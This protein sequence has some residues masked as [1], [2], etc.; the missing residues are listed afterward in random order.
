MTA[1]YLGE[2]DYGGSISVIHNDS[3]NASSGHQGPIVVDDAQL[4]F[5]AHFHR[6]GPDLI[7]TGR[8]GH[9]HIV[10]DYFATEHPRALAAPNGAVLRSDLV[11]LL[12]GSVA[13]NEYAQAGGAAPSAPQPIGRVEKIVGEVTVLRNGVAVTLNV[14]DAVYQSDVVQ[15]GANSSAGIAFPDG[16]AFNLVANTRMALSDYSYDANSNSNSALFNLV[17]GGFSFVAGKVA[18]TGDMKIGTPAATMGIRGTAGWVF[19]DQVA[20][21]TANAGNVTVHFSAVFDSVTNTESTYTLYAVDANGQL[22]HDPNGNLISLATVSSTQNGLVTN[23]SINPN[24]IGQ[25]A[26]AVVNVA[27]PDFNQQQFANLVVPQVLDM[28]K[29]AIQ[30]YQNQQNNQN[31]PTNPQSNP[32]SSG[33]GNPQPPSNNNN[34]N[35][36]L[37]QLIQNNGGT[38]TTITVVSNETPATTTNTNNNPQPV[39]PPT[40]PTGSQTYI[41]EATGNTP[42]PFQTPTVYNIPNSFPSPSDNLVDNLA[43]PMV[44]DDSRSINELTVGSIATVEAVGNATT[45]STPGSLTVGGTTDDSGLIKADSTVSDP[46]ITFSSAVTVEGGGVIEAFANGNLAEIVFD[47]GATIDTTGEIEATGVDAIVQ[48]AAGAVDDFGTILAS[49]GGAITFDAGVTVEASGEIQADGSGSTV[50]VTGSGAVDDFGQIVASDGG[51]ITFDVGVT[52]EAGGDI[53]AVSGSN[54]GDVIFAS[55]VTLESAAGQNAGGQVVASGKGASVTFDYG[56]TVGAGAEIEATGTGA[57]VYITNI[58]G[59]Q[60]VNSGLI[61]ADN[62]GAITFFDVQVE[63]AGGTIEAEGSV[64]SGATVPLIELSG[65]DIVGGTLETTDNGLI[66]VG[67]GLEATFFDGSTSEGPVTVIGEV[68]VDAGD[69]LEL[70]GTIDNSGDIS[71]GSGSE[72]LIGEQVTLDDSGTIDLGGGTLTGVAGS[73]DELIND[74]NE[75]TGTGT[76]ENL[77]VVNENGGSVYVDS[78]QTLTL[79]NATIDGG[80]DTGSGATID[81]QTGTNNAGS[82]LE[83]VA[84]SDPNINVSGTLTLNGDTISGG[85]IDL[86]LGTAS[87][88]PIEIASNIPADP[89]AIGPVV[90]A[91]GQFVAFIAS[92][93]LPGQGGGDTIGQIE[94]YSVAND[95]LTNISALV[96]QA[97]L[98]AGEAYSDV[99]SISDNG[100]MVVFEGKYTTDNGPTSDVFLYNSQAAAGSQVT[101]VRADAGSA[102]IDG[103]G[104]VIA[105]EG[106]TSDNGGTHILL[107]NDSGVVQAEI[108]GD[109]NYVPPNN[110]SDNFG[111]DG[112][113]YNPALSDDGSDVA[114]WSTASEITVTQGASVYT[115]NTGNTAETSAEIYVY[116]TQTHTLKDA[117]LGIGGVPGD[118]DSG[119]LS[120]TDE[121]SSWAPSISGN[122]RFVV[123][124]STADNLVNGVGDVNDDVSNIFLYDSHTGKIT[125]V[126]DANGATITG[127]SMRASIS[128]DGKTLT[129]ASDDDNLPGANGGWQSYMVSIDPLTGAPSAPELL[130]AG[131][132]GADNGQNNLASD[133]S[134]GGGVTA[135]GGAAFAFNTDQGQAVLGTGATAGTITFSDVSVTDYNGA[136]DSLT[137]TISVAHGTLSS[138]VGLSGLTIVGGNDGSHGTLEVTGTLA[139]ID[140]A[141]QAGVTYTPG[142]PPSASD[143]LSL[144]VTDTTTGETASFISQFQPQA[145]NPSQIFTDASTSSGQYDIF[146]SEQQTV[147]VTADT[148]IN[149]GATIDGGLITISSGVALTLNDITDNDTAIHDFSTVGSTVGGGTVAF[150]GSSTLLGTGIYGATNH[151]GQPISDVTIGSGVTVTLDDVVFKNIA[152]TVT[153][154]GTTPSLQIDAGYT[155]S[156]AGNSSFGGP[157]GTGSI[158]IDNNGHIV[159]DGTLDIGFSEVTFEGTGTVT[160]NGENTGTAV[161]TLINEGNTIDGYSTFGSN[162]TIENLAGSNNPAGSFDADVAGQAM[163]FETGHTIVND[164]TFIAN[165]GILEIFDQVSG[166]GSAIIE[167]GGTL[168]IGNA[169]SQ[170]ITFEGAGTLQ[171]DEQQQ[172]NAEAYAGN[173]VADTGIVSGVAA[174]DVIDL[175]GF[176]SHPGDTFQVLTSYNATTNDTTLTV[177]DT[178]D[179]STEFSAPI[180]LS[181]NYENPGELVATIDGHGGV[182][183]TALPVVGFSDIISFNSGVINTN[184]QVAPA[185]SDGGAT[186]QLTD[187]NS[188]EAA[189]WFANNQVSI[190]A[191]TASFDY[192]ATPQGGNLADGL[193]FILQ[194]SSAGLSALGGR[195]S[196]LGYGTD[197]G[198]GGTA[199]SPSAAIELN[200]YTAPGDTTPGSHMP[201]TNF[202]ENG[203]TGSYYSTGDVDFWD[204]GDTVQV[205][206]SY[207][208]STL[209]E[210]LTDLVTGATY[211]TNYDNIDLA[212][213]LGSNTAYVGFSAG[214]GGGA[215]AQAVSNFTYLPGAA[216]E[217]K[218]AEN[219]PVLLPGLGVSDVNASDTLTVTLDVGHGTLSLGSTTGLTIVGDNDGSHGA[220]EFTGLLSAVDA[221]L[222]S[223]LTYAPTTGFTGTDTLTFTAGDGGVD[224]LPDNLTINVSAP[225]PAPDDWTGQNGNWSNTDD[226]DN[227]APTTNSEVNITV[228]GAVVTYDSSSSPDTIYS[229]TTNNGAKLEID[230]GTSLSV[231][232]SIDAQSEVD[233]AGTLIV[234]GGTLDLVTNS[235]EVE[236]TQ[237]TL[238]LIHDVNNSGGTIAAYDTGS[239]G[240]VGSTIQLANDVTVTGGSLVIGN[241]LVGDYNDT[242]SLDRFNDAALQNTTVNLSGAID[243]G[244]TSG[245]ILT[246]DD[247]TVIGGAGNGILSVGASGEVKIETDNVSTGIAATLDDVNVALQSNGNSSGTVQVDGSQSAATLTLTD[248]T[249]ISGGVL[250]IGLSGT[251]EVDAGS[252]THGG[253]G[254]TFDDVTVDNLGTLAVGDDSSDPSGAILRLTDGTAIDSGNLIIGI[255]GNIVVESGTNSS[256]V[257]FDGVTVTLDNELQ[258]E[259]NATLLIDGN[260]SFEGIGPVADEGTL[261]IEFGATLT[262]DNEVAIFAGGSVVNDGTLQATSSILSVENA[263]DNSSGTVLAS[264]GFIDFFLGVAG[265]AAT[266]SGGGKLEYGW[267]SNVATAFNGVGTLVLDHQNQLDPKYMLPSSLVIGG[268]TFTTSS[269]VGAVSGFG[270][271][272]TIDITDLAYSVSETVTWT[273]LTTGVNA[274]GALTIDNNGQIASIMLDGTY[275]QGD[276][277]LSSDGLTVNSGNPGTDVVFNDQSWGELQYPTIVD[278][279]HLFGVNPQYDSS[280]NVVVLAYDD[281]TGYSTGETSYTVTPNVESLDPFFLPGPHASQSTT[282]YSVQAPGRYILAVPNINYSAANSPDGVAGVF[283]LGIYLFK[284]TI[285]GVSGIWQTTATPDTNGDGGVTFGSPTEIGTTGTTDETIFNLRDAVRTTS[286]VAQSYA[287]VWDQFSGTSTTTGSYSIE[288]QAVSINGSA[289][290]PA[291]VLTPTTVLSIPVAASGLAWTDLPAW[292]FKPGGGTGNYVL[293]LAESSNGGTDNVLHFQ[294]YKISSGALV[295]GTVAFNV[296]A[297]LSAYASGATNEIIQPIVATLSPYPGQVAEAVQFVQS[298]DNGNDYFVAWNETV[299][300]SNGTHDQVEFA[301]VSSS[302]TQLTLPSSISAFQIADGQAQN[303][304]IGEFTD[305]VHSTQDDVVVVYGDDTGT[306]IN[307]YAVTSN[308]TV[309]T[310]I[311]SITDAT[312]QAFDNLTVLGDGRIAI[313]YDDTVNPSNSTSQYDFQIFDLRTQGLDE[314]LS[315]TQNNYIAGTH[316]TDTVIGANTVN[317][318]YYFV[319][320]DT[321]SGPGPSDTFTGGTGGGWNIAIFA[322]ARSDYSITQNGSAF[323]IASDGADQAHTGS[324]TVTNVQFLAFDPASDPTPQN[325]VID[326]NGGTFVILEGNSAIDIASGAAAEIDTGAAYTGLVTFTG[327]AGTLQVDQFDGLTGQ[328]AGI[329]AGDANQVL[330]LD[331]FNAQTGDGFTVAANHTGSVTVLTVTDSHNGD[332]EQVTLQGDYAADAGVSWNTTNDGHGGVDVFDPLIA[333]TDGSVLTISDANPSDPTIV[334]GGPVELENGATLHQSSPGSE[335]VTFAGTQGAV[336]IDDPSTF[337]GTVSGITGSGDQ[338]DLGGFGSHQ[339][340]AF[341]ATTAY[342][343]SDTILT[344]TDT[345]NHSSAESV[346]LAGNYTGDIFTAAYDGNGGADVVGSPAADSTSVVSTANGDSV[347]GVVAFANTDVSDNLSMSADGLNYAGST[348]LV[349]QSIDA[350]GN[351]AVNFSIDL[352]S[353]QVGN[354]QTL[355]Q[356]YDVALNNTNPAANQSQTV[357]VTVGGPGNDHFVF[358]PGVGADTVVNFNAQQDTVELDHFANVQTAQQLQA[359]ITTDTHGDAVIDLGHQDSITFANT[360]SAQLQ[361]AIQAGHILLH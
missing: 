248:G 130:S 144:N 51:L 252:S 94:L 176:N 290:S 342:N 319:G 212:Q 1:A 249:K 169:Y 113:V 254:G 79:I 164:G 174:G 338:I 159:H 333:T 188:I 273:Q 138:V 7:L 114:F 33:S 359:L 93:N 117:S 283:A 16:T 303:V 284:G 148:T 63:N 127:D 358:A 332:S 289:S 292:D 55:G 161:N 313:T 153:S 133:V 181:G 20:N 322:D 184:G 10:P 85:T 125:A 219:M 91:G 5:S 274:S 31:Q 162:L 253:S 269:Y 37:Q 308:G 203:D 87:P 62:G 195:G 46:T 64:A 9:N 120:T 351:M 346:T 240:A 316:F 76:I 194:D 152:L 340:D 49:G 3:A 122:G 201:G 262:T 78:G 116:D 137:L 77:T 243:V 25:L 250:S 291:N 143:T 84:I 288:I 150:T 100:H 95:E 315:A 350:N 23:V 140:A 230:S 198:G 102:A 298:P 225:P 302:G 236:I 104:T 172:G 300:D 109:P 26:Q 22:L 177:S 68:Q 242:L 103:L 92:E 73:A 118:G 304:R 193:A 183:V 98:H 266:I 199:I 11:E 355:T 264:G 232:Q 4:L 48:F 326:A 142:S 160:E 141:L 34:E 83:N 206:L 187:G 189:S 146:L 314:T 81:V 223:G 325:N 129:F 90:S 57:S 301:A 330:D 53:E 61:E 27:P 245:A 324:L 228:S 149:D 334:E 312:S 99:P 293:A 231:T 343:G 354:G 265:G 132:P 136:S 229:L 281:T 86:S 277:A 287:A 272:D 309:V 196:S 336:V 233:N 328:I 156:W 82:T 295:A 119:T 39:V 210:T 311:D 255:G 353:N 267:S 179:G 197:T 121:N 139:A 190:D 173:A 89:Y 352:D 217:I 101:L 21:V 356:S 329:T 35:P 6:A 270:A 323:I 280:G 335:S 237:G 297:N 360:T 123:Y 45:P 19:E 107:M 246:L 182:D 126:T 318:E 147:D 221:A 345:T 276:F 13:P 238:D 261:E 96:P 227:G 226:W 36:P 211:S 75:I 163:V 207:D 175:T 8:D 215:S 12:A 157:D 40:T 208:G 209:S 200:L 348:S 279:E 56:V 247:G 168:E 59:P 344:V 306:H 305:P 44:V 256:D 268:T 67:A 134:D 115:F 191:F 58:G 294:N 251:V 285:G 108:A 106:S 42:T 213:I 234:P 286:G 128:A 145:T 341:A 71:L 361:Q 347:S 17:E 2:G 70:L 180:T 97:D 307:E 65:V 258:V 80:L 224:S 111:N 218:T 282:S 185:I 171:F 349:G 235:G 331:G 112:S 337:T 357:S 74:G 321:T 72:F 50:L 47:G 151:S 32:S 278:G 135:F 327:S 204:T 38:P 154:D 15:T 339:G 299:A 239:G 202:A 29:Q 296:T 41:F 131:F 66:E 155:F 320:Q 28:A 105:A 124:Q 192:Q 275:S 52:V 18:H 220:L 158:I 170:N 24:G 310:L 167:Q 222:A 30:Q 14:G 244:V 317:N 271:G 88:Q 241:A 60:V 186:L 216:N 263:V 43:A 166:T 69:S 205:A 259:A 260:T 178:Q 214:T 257:T 165:G 110:N 54:A